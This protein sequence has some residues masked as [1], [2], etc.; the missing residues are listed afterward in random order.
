VEQ[1]LFINGVWKGFYANAATLP[2]NER[3]VIIRGLIRTPM[4]TYSESPVLPLTSRYETGLFSIPDLA[5][6]FRSGMILSY[7]DIVKSRL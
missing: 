5:D 2:V 4:G 1:Y 7:D 6:A 3:S